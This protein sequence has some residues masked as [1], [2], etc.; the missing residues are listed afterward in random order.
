[1]IKKI[2]YLFSFSEDADRLDYFYVWLGSLIFGGGFMFLGVYYYEN[3]LEQFIFPFII[4]LLIITLANTSRRINDLDK[5]PAYVLLIF[6]PIVQLIFIL[7]LMFT[8]GRK[9]S[10]RSGVKMGL[11]KKEIIKEII[12]LLIGFAVATIFFNIIFSTII[13]WIILLRK[14]TESTA[15]I[16][17]WGRSI[18]GV[19]WILVFGFMYIF[20]D[21]SI[22]SPQQSS[23]S[24]TLL[25]IFIFQPLLWFVLFFIGAIVEKNKS[26]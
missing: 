11:M 20:D 22:Y 26:K 1:M 6:I 4:I 8:P 2:K 10:L 23:L 3:L 18:F 19:L 13:L 9:F 17:L 15:I 25:S 24:K 12:I 21:Y 5:H 16:S 7:Y 14:T